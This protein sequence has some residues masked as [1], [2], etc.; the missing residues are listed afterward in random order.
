MWVFEQLQAHRWCQGFILE[1]TLRECLIHGDTYESLHVMSIFTIRTTCGK[2]HRV[3]PTKEEGCAIGDMKIK[4]YHI[5]AFSTIQNKGNPAGVV[6]N[7]REL[8]DEQM[9]GTA[10]VVGF[11]ETAFLL[12]SDQADYRI[13]YFTPGH[14]INLC[15][16]A[17]M[18]AVHAM[19]T[20]GLL[21]DK[22]EFTIETKAGVL[23]I[24]L[25]PDGITMKQA[26][27]QF[28]EFNGSLEELA[29]S[30][31]IDVDDIDT[32][33]PTLYGSTGTWTLL[34]PIRRLDIF[35]R[36][37][38]NN[39]LFPGILKEMP[40]ASVHPFCLETYDPH[41]HMHARH[42]S[43]PYSGT[44]EDPV[45]GTASGVMGAYYARHIKKESW[46]RLCIE[47]GQEIGRDGRVYVTVRN[48]DDIEITGNAVYVSEFEVR[49][50]GGSN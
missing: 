1:G 44:I 10:A 3:S 34:V 9:R 26:A 45:T 29:S 36:M 23:P 18:A 8:P 17:T 41:A 33:L 20:R 25:H 4:V 42:F 32:E 47:Q 12:P 50:G 14:E 39:E 35:Q 13:R 16:H 48:G 43:S 7:G 40:R 30:I 22:P 15:G 46:L 28:R 11:N 6:L 38:P 27:P 5:D 19:K 2:S 37:K 21:G 24:Q 49:L 31:G